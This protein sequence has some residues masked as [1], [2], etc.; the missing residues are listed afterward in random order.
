MAPRPIIQIPIKFLAIETERILF[1]AAERRTEGCSIDIAEKKSHRR[2]KKGG[3]TPPPAPP[4]PPPRP[5]PRA[6]PPPPPGP[7]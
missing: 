4:A 6:P 5:P 3:G 7:A 1:R 2:D